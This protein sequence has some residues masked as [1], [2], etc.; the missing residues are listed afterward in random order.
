MLAGY[1]PRKFRL[2]G[3]IAQVVDLGSTD[4][5]SEVVDSSPFGDGVG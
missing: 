5:E 3:Q 1:L 4:V 2:G